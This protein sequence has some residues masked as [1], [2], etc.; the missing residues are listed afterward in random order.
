[1]VRA[2]MKQTEKNMFHFLVMQNNVLLETWC[3]AGFGCFLYTVKFQG[4]PVEWIA[5][6]LP[7]GRMETLDGNILIQGHIEV[8]F[9]ATLLSSGALFPMPHHHRARE[10]CVSHQG[11]ETIF[12]NV[13][14]RLVCMRTV[15]SL[16]V[17]PLP[18]L[19]T[20]SSLSHYSPPG[21]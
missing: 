15:R 18:A 8:R 16:L 6:R 5:S 3:V 19:F 9:E 13:F 17:Q 1:M 4:S 21:W 2:E 11:R 10:A 12:H 20:T 7:V 14:A